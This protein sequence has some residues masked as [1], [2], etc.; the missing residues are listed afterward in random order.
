MGNLWDP[1]Y[2]KYNCIDL[3]EIANRIVFNNNKMRRWGKSSLEKTI[4]VLEEAAGVGNG[5]GPE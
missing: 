1:L 5:V 2:Q 3:S 4:S